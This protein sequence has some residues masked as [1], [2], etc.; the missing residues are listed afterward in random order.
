[1]RPLLGLLAF[2]PCLAACSD[3][4]PGGAPPPAPDAG[5]DAGPASF[6]SALYPEDW[7]PSF[8]D[9]EGHFLHDFSY[10]GYHHAE[11]PPGAPAAAPIF[12]VVTQGADP[13]GQMDATL[14]VQ[15]AIDA[16]AAQGGGIVT[17]PEGLYRID[18]KL[19]VSASGVVLR[20]AGATKS[21]LHFTRSAGMDYDAHLAFLGKAEPNLELPLAVD[22]TSRADVVEVASAE[23][24]APGD[25]VLLGWSI[26]PAFLEEHGM[27]GT[28]TAFNDTW[29][30]FFRRTV[31]AV[32]KTS[33][34]HRITLDV[35]LRYPAKLRDG[36]SLK[37]VTGLLRECGVESLGVSNAVSWAEAWAASQVHAID[38]RRVVDCWIKDVASFPSPAAPAEGPGSGAHLASG[39]ILL[40]ETTR[41][42]VQH[43][44]LGLAQN[45]GGGGNGYLFEIRRSNEILIADSEGDGGRHNFIQNWGFGTTGCVF[46]RIQSKNG[47]SLTDMN[48]ASGFTG[49]SEFHHSLATANLIDASTFDDGFSIVN[50]ND[51]STGAGHTGTENVLWNNR[52]KGALRSL[53]FGTGYVIGTEGLYVTTESPLPMALGTQPVDWVEGLD[54]GDALDPPSLYEDQRSRRRAR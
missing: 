15:A 20:G 10:A 8:T 16:A 27:T 37:R 30:P 2:L 26:T 41:V 50:R 45:R 34:P 51:E 33:S 5:T 21:R 42:T 24:L 4:P 17:F 6:R 7:T 47:E 14:A 38:L 35:P 3:E 18:D 19:V 22:A 49:L 43:V 44:S 25:D 23:D 31:A 54:E 32:D 36:A 46:L 52:G 11:A 39:G 12:D 40:E 28:W 13:T 1:M 9:A 48:D 29:Q 53:Q